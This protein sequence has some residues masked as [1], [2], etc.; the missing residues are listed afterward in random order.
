[1][2]LTHTREEHPATSQSFGAS[3]ESRSDPGLP[4]SS[5]SVASAESLASPPRASERA[6][7]VSELRPSPRPTAT[8][9]R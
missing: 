9:P 5:V 7:P 4:F 6:S 8:M 3:A 2:L 1:M